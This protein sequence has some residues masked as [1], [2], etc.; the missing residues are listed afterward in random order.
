MTSIEQQKRGSA[1]IL[2]CDVS[3]LQ[4][5]VA[6]NHKSTWKQNWEGGS[7]YVDYPFSVTT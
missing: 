1:E 2:A 7:I 5:I 3:A 4:L 6:R